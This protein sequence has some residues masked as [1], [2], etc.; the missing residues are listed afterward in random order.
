M[1][2]LSCV[3]FVGMG[4]AGAIQEYI[5]FRLRIMTCPKCLTFWSVLIYSLF[6]GEGVIQSIAVSFIISYI[7]LWAAL[8]LDALTI[9][10]NMLYEKITRNQRTA[11]EERPEA[12]KEGTA[13]DNADI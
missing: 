7:S 9:L 11:D 8:L 13:S 6:S 1:I 10:Y 4:L 2:A 3:L 5:P 12:D